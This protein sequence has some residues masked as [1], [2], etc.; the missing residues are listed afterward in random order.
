V[1]TLCASLSRKSTGFLRQSE[2]ARVGAANGAGD[3]EKHDDILNII[4]RHVCEGGA[5]RKSDAAAVCIRPLINFVQKTALRGIRG[6]TRG[7]VHID[8]IHGA[9]PRALRGS[10]V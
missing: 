6:R 9:W 8:Y 2:K 4:K 7:C 10:A 1:R 3:L 5:A